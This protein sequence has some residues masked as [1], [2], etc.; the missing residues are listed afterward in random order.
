VALP[1]RSSPRRRE[2]LDATALPVG[3]LDVFIDSFIDA[4][5]DPND[6]EVFRA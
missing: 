6:K 5:L 2:L 3:Y 4:I 1:P